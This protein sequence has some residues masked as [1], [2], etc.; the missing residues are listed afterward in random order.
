MKNFT[1]TKYHRKLSVW[2]FATFLSIQIIKYLLENV[3]DFQ[4]KNQ[5]LLF[6]GLFAFGVVIMSFTNTIQIIRKLNFRKNVLYI[7]VSS[8]PALIFLFG[9]VLLF[10]NDSYEF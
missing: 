1:K 10:F 4:F 8:I 5:V 3:S 2:I 9:L 7:F 6:L